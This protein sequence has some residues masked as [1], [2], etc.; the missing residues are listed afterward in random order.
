MAKRKRPQAKH[1]PK[2]RSSQNDKRKRLD[3]PNPGRKRTVKMKVRLTG[4]MADLEKLMPRC[5]LDSFAFQVVHIYCDG[6][7]HFCFA[8]LTDVQRFPR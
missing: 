8:D 4:K 3:T 7:R 1:N 6:L 5:N 2:G